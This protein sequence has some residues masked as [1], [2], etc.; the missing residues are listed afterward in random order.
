MEVACNYMALKENVLDLSHFAYVHEATLAVS[1]WVAPPRVEKTPETVSYHQ[2][3]DLMPLPAHY[4]VPSGIGCEHRVNRHAWGSYVSPALQLAG[5]DI[6]DPAG[7]VGGRQAFTLRILHA[8][9][10]IDEGQCRYWWFF[11]QDYGHGPDAAERLTERIE[12]AF[13]EDKVVLEAT[14]AMVRRDPRGRDTLD[15]S[16]GCDHAGVEARRRVQR[17]ADASPATADAAGGGHRATSSGAVG[18]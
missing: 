4:G 6:D 18:Q 9:T 13:L 2:Q 16:V 5:V 12:A 8:T 3:F 15:L 1:D 17:L 7:R 10:P 11:S 14:E